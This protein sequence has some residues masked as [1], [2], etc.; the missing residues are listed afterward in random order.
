MGKNNK[1]EYKTNDLVFGQLRGYPWWPG[2][3]LQKESSGE[4]RV[5]FFG[6]FTYAV[7]NNRKIRPFVSTPRKFDKKNH[8]LSQAIKSALRVMK[9]ESTIKMEREAVLKPV[10]VSRKVVKKEDKTKKIKKVDSRK[11]SKRSGAIHKK[12]KTKK[13]KTSALELIN[14][15]RIEE[16]EASKSINIE[17]RGKSLR[18]NKMSMSWNLEGLNEGLEF[19]MAKSERG[20]GEKGFFDEMIETKSVKPSEKP[21]KIG[22]EMESNLEINKVREFMNDQSEIAILNQTKNSLRSLENMEALLTQKR[23]THSR[24]D[25]NKVKNIL[26]NVIPLDKESVVSKCPSILGF[27]GKGDLMNVSMSENINFS[28]FLKKEQDSENYIGK[29][30]FEKIEKEMLE[31]IN[32]MKQTRSV[33]QL[34]ERLKQWHDELE[35][36]PDFKHIVDTNIGKYLSNI[37]SFCNKQLNETIH[38]NSILR[39]IKDFQ[40]IIIDK[41]SQNFFGCEDSSVISKDFI[42]LMCNQSPKSKDLTLLNHSFPSPKY[43]GK[44]QYI[45]GNEIRN[46]RPSN[47]R[48]ALLKTHQEPRSQTSRRKMTDLIYLDNYSVKGNMKGIHLNKTFDGHLNKSI[49]IDK[50]GDETIFED[51][52]VLTMKK[53]TDTETHWNVDNVI[54]KETQRK[55]STKIAKRLFW[56]KGIPQM[57]GELAKK[58]GI[59]IERIIRMDCKTKNQYQLQILK[60]IEILNKSGKDFYLTYLRHDQ[61]K[62]EVRKLKVLLREKMQCN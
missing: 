33:G 34:E 3:I 55:V 36:K 61:G 15:T 30:N 44:Q 57:K 37:R 13:V 39:K 48:K 46:R 40:N 12:P 52:S 51:Q 5:V 2:Y 53:E 4:Y 18:V 28:K 20:G 60:L 43:D 27:G 14:D 59:I 38:Y 41:I 31:L 19:G 58:L 22:I 23:E 42:A 35:L 10:R 26:K 21:L 1:E 25:L 16:I 24:T 9:K 49:Q 6:D 17:S 45:L 8:K 50:G 47:L 32:L 56:I 11:K 29:A 7:L 54:D 62:C